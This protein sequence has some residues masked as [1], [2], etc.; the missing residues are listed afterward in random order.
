MKILKCTQN[1]VVVNFSDDIRI[2]HDALNIELT[3]HVPILT[4]KL[5]L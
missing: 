3:Q 2:A 4:F 1:D 5:T